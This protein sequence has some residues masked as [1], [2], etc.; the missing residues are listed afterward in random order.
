MDATPEFKRDVL[1]S[2]RPHYASKI[3]DGE[4][5]VELRRKF[6]EIG[7]TGMTALIYSSSPVSAVVGYACI[8]NV[9]KLPVSRIW[10]EHGA[11]A[12]VSKGEF[13]AYFA[14]LRDG[15]AIVFESV[16]P[17]KKLVTAGD[18]QAQFGIVPPQS[19]RYVTGEC[20]ALLSDEQFQTSHRHKRRYRARGPS[21]RTGVAR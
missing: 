1:V 16:Q 14:G 4:K 8:K 20:V 6:T 5:T 15:F 10:K 2:I 19:Y 18:L 9:L 12:C 3:L 7:A 11:A 13:D 17:L 21:A